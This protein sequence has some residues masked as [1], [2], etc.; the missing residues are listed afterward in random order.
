MRDSRDKVPS[1]LGFYGC[2]GTH[3]LGNSYT[4]EHLIG[5]GLEFRAL[6]HYCHGGKRSGMKADMVLRKELR[7][8]LLDSQAAGSDCHIRPGLS[9]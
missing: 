9:I 1:L 2:E 3:D 6:D 7:I 5:A 8:L 4:G